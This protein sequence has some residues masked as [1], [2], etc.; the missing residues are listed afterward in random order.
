MDDPKADA[1]D[2]MTD[3]DEPVEVIQPG[4]PTNTIRAFRPTSPVPDPAPGAHAPED[5]ASPS[6]PVLETPWPA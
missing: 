2:R 6:V 1:L 4:G 3:W 5:T